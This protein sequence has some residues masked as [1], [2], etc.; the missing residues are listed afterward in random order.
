MTNADRLQ[1]WNQMYDQTPERWRFQ[2]AVWALVAIGVVNM[3]LTVAVGFPFALLVGLAIVAMAV[4]RVPY[5]LGWLRADGGTAGGGGGAARMEITAPAWVLRANR[6]YD[7]LDETQAPVR[8]LAALAI[9]GAITMLLTFATG[10]PLRPA[11]PAGGAGPDRDPRALRGRL[12]QRTPRRR[13]AG[14]RSPWSPPRR[15]SATMSAQQR[16]LVPPR[17]RRRPTARPVAGRGR[18]QNRQGPARRRPG[19]PGTSVLTAAPAAAPPRAAADEGAPVP[20]H[21]DNGASWSAQARYP[22]VMARIGPTPLALAGA[23]ARRRRALAPVL[24]ALALPGCEAMERMDYLDRFFEPTLAYRPVVAMDPAPA[25][26]TDRHFQDSVVA[27]EPRPNPPTARS[28]ADWDPPPGPVV[29]M[30]PRP[31]P[32]VTQAAVAADGNAQ[33]NRARA[34]EPP[35]QEAAAAPQAADPEARTRLLVRQNPWL[36]Q[37]WMELTPAQQARV[38]RQLQRG[39]MVLAAERA[40]PAVAWDSMGLAD[41]ARLIF[42]G[43]QPLERPAPPERRDGS[44][45]ARNS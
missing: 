12:V 18:A 24:L 28:T 4:V 25:P 33:P 31:N 36:T 14:R 3:L 13:R 21:R 10:L 20:Q 17:R 44:T 37:F 16:H 29:A 27:M 1:R 19:P 2:L 39:G 6:W 22:G 9:P 8:V 38:E 34:A 23:P 26:L 32:P 40:E 5:A 30:E 7:G 42:G 45:W 35:R 41:R 43:G 11:V 15:G